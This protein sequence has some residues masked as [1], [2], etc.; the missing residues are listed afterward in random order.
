MTDVQFNE[1]DYGARTRFQTR[2]GFPTRLVM[3]LGL[4][5]NREQAPKV[6]LVIAV[7]ALMVMF[8]VGFGGGNNIDESTYELPEGQIMP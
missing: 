6:L 2:D 8:V 7:L 3:K 4:A 5:K 1:Q